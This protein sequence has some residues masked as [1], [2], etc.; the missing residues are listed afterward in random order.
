MVL[1]VSYIDVLCTGVHWPHGGL[2]LCRGLFR[3]D[4]C[5]SAGAH[6]GVCSAAL[7]D[8]DVVCRR[9]RVHGYMRVHLSYAH[10][11]VSVCVSYD[12]Y[13]CMR[14]SACG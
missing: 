12:I 8:D 14:C 13:V 3:V 6:A 10:V 11:S 5:Q 4:L 2:L 9:P 7:V 1:H